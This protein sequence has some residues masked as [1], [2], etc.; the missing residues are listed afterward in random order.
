VHWRYIGQGKPQ[1]NAF[2]VSRNDCL[3]DEILN[4]KLFDT[5]DD[6]HRKSVR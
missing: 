2:I 4:E 3:R 1:Q 5:L 6:A